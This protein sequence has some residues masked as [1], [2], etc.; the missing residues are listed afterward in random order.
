MLLRKYFI[1]TI[2]G[3]NSERNDFQSEDIVPFISY[4]YG[5]TS[6]EKLLQCFWLRICKYS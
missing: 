2:R 6:L 1:A 3:A 5:F 4:E